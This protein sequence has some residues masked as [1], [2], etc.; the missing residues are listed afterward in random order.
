MSLGI[1]ERSRPGT[2]W[3]PLLRRGR[4]C[5][6]GRRLCKA[7]AGKRG[8]TTHKKKLLI[9]ASKLGYQTRGFAEA[10]EKLGVEVLFGT[11]RCHQLENPWGDE[12]LALHFERGR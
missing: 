1:V 11:D 12:A 10:A 7:E 9:L 2:S 3:F 6:R 5:G 8:M 4:G